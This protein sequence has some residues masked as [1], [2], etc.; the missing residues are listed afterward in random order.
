MYSYEQFDAFEQLSVSAKTRAEAVLAG[1]TEPTRGFANMASMRT[2][3]FTSQAT[4]GGKSEV[5]GKK[6][7]RSALK[8]AEKAEVTELLA[9][10]E[11]RIRTRQHVSECFSAAELI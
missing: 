9:L 1:S 11:V 4:A 10:A 7:G 2:V 5:A 8:D 6:K 3:S